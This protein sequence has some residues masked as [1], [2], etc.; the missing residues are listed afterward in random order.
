MA[1]T[2]SARIYT[3]DAPRLLKLQFAVASKEGELPTV[4]EV[5]HRL[6]DMAEERGNVQE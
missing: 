5:I 2:S 4:A 1:D 6:I 3:S